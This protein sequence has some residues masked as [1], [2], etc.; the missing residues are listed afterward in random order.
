MKI[1]PEFS[2]RF[3]EDDICIVRLGPDGTEEF[4]SPLSASAAM[5]WEGIERGLSRETLIEMVANE[6]DGAD[7]ETVAA[8]LDALMAQ[9]IALGYAE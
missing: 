7:R 5:A 9:L 8:D 6:F 3:D 4:V 2:V 1:K